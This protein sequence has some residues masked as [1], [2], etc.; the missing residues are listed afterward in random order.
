MSFH[1]TAIKRMGEYKESALYLSNE[2]RAYTTK[3]RGQLRK[4]ILPEPKWNL[5][6]TNLPYFEEIKRGTNEVSGLKIPKYFCHMT[7]SQA[8]AVNFFYPMIRHNK[9]NSVLK[10]IGIN[11]EVAN[12]AQ[13]IQFEYKSSIDGNRS[14]IDVYI[15]LMN[16][17]GVYVEVKFSESE[18]GRNQSKDWDNFYKKYYNAA[19]VVFPDKVNEQDQESRRWCLSNYQIIRNT[20]HT[21]GEETNLALQ[22]SRDPN[23]DSGKFLPYNYIVFLYPAHNKSLHY[24]VEKAHSSLADDH[25]R[26]HVILKHWEDLL[27]DLDHEMRGDS[28]LELLG[29]EFR[30]KYFF[31]QAFPHF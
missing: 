19:R 16:E 2:I 13:K 15:P 14:S 25:L 29:Q 5:I 6:E 31:W 10:A 21:L 23:I 30:G 17:R 26:S 18:F 4:H 22:K 27:N 24:Q 3:Y 28:E 1:K 12:P 8:M 7:S 20:V 11:N 9:I